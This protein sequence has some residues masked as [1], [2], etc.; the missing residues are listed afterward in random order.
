MGIVVRDRI[1]VLVFALKVNIGTEV[2]ID[3]AVAVVVCGGHAGE[4]A[5]RRGSKSKRF[6]L[7]LKRA[8]ALV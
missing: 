7:M 4:S 2:E 8:I 3:T 5:L 6:R 1:A